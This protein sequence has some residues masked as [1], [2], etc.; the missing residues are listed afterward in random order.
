MNT[1]YLVLSLVIGPLIGGGLVYYIQSRIRVKEARDTA[2]IHAEATA[3]A[4]PYAVLQQQ[5]ITKDQ[6]LASAQGLHHAFVES[7]MARSDA[8]TQ[9]ILAL[10]EQVRVQT[11]NLKDLGS[12]LDTHRTESSARAGKIYEQIGKVNERLAGL[13]ANVK[14]SLET[15]SDAAKTAKDAA[16]T[17]D[18]VARETRTA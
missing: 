14:N 8:T 18:R 5:L 4:T 10:A 2:G 7:T 13:E 1:T 15:A 16:E 12:G 9:A 3:V 17:L 11:G 6:Q